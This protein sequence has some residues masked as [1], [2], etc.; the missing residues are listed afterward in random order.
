MSWVSDNV[1]GG[2]A[3]DA[4]KQQTAALE[5]AQIL[6]Q[7]GVTQARNDVN[8][9]FPI[10]NQNMLTGATGALDVYNQTAPQQMQLA[11]Q[12]N[13]NAQEALLAG[14]PQMN[15]ALL[16]NAVDYSGLQSQQQQVPSFNYSMPNFNMG[17]QATQP[18]ATPEV[19]LNAIMGALG[20]KIMSGFGG[21]GASVG[22]TNM[23]R[24]K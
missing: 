13:V 10:A 22:G 5:Q 8:S 17:Q 12:G 14:L 4:A 15:N 1:F 21:N 11:Q 3:K 18:Q 9:L 7:E 20:G 2:A 23:Q 6:T 24:M 16:G 19:D